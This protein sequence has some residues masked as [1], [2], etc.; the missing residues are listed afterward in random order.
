MKHIL[1]IRQNESAQSKRNIPHPILPPITFLNPPNSHTSS[2]GKDQT[3]PHITPTKEDALLLDIER[4]MQLEIRNGEPSKDPEYKDNDLLMDIKLEMVMEMGESTHTT[5]APRCIIHKDTPQPQACHTIQPNVIENARTAPETQVC[6]TMEMIRIH[7]S[8]QSPPANLQEMAETMLWHN[9]YPNTH[10]KSHQNLSNE[11]TNCPHANAPFG[12]PIPIMQWIAN[13][14][15]VH[16]ERL[17]HPR[18]AAM[19]PILVPT[20]EPELITSHPYPAHGGVTDPLTPQHWS[21]H[22]SVIK[23]PQPKQT[24]GGDRR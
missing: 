13:T 23:L 14:F 9:S 19:I 6:K 5:T 20:Y 3:Q 22:P 24:N 2:T 10:D 16:T 8:P 11:E 7:A 1:V 12:L 18:C 17:T 21:E 15:T 4:E